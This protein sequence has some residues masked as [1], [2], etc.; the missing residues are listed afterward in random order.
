M[1]IIWVV[2]GQ[3]L[4]EMNQLSDANGY[5]K[6]TIPIKQQTSNEL[7]TDNSVA[8]ISIVISCFLMEM[9]QL[10]DVKSI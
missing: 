10:A 9:N 5:F 3:C 2:I 1:I 8:T 4:M 6:Q 7:A